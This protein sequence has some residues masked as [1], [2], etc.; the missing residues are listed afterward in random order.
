MAV[1]DSS[2]LPHK[3]CSLRHLITNGRNPTESWQNS[4][5]KGKQKV[6]NRQTLILTSNLHDSNITFF[7][8]SK[9]DVSDFKCLCVL[10]WLNLS[11][12][13]IAFGYTPHWKSWRNSW[14]HFLCFIIIWRGDI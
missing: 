4:F 12:Y 1:P 11:E 3:Q 10:L 9:E 14:Q 2:V 6:I 5:F 7:P 8:N 13:F